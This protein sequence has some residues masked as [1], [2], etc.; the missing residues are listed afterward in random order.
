MEN[1]NTPVSFALFSDPG[2]GASQVVREEIG[3]VIFYSW[4]RKTKLVNISATIVN[5][6]SDHAETIA[7]IYAPHIFIGDDFFG[8]AIHQDRAVM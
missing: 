5:K 4:R 7:Q 1:D 3:L 2:A 6:E 8:G